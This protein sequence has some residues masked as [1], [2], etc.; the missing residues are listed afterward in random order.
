VVLNDGSPKGHRIS[1]GKEYSVFDE[2]Q[3]LE[4]SVYQTFSVKCKP[5]E[6]DVNF[7][8]LRARC[9]EARIGIEDWTAV[10]WLCQKCSEGTP[11]ET[12]DKELK[13]DPEEYHIAFAANSLETLEA[14]LYSW[15][16]EIGIE[17]YD[18]VRHSIAKSEE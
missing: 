18:P 3:H 15:S 9:R 10:E 5:T 2:I 1:E 12:H 14:V 4:R 13:S 6:L 17:Y 8:N 16:D 11:H 7:E